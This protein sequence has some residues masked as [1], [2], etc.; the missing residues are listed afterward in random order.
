M[1]I[2]DRDKDIKR[3]YDKLELGAEVHRLDFLLINMLGLQTKIP[4]NSTAN[5]IMGE[6]ITLLQGKRNLMVE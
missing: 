1:C 6:A 4:E 2:R 3:F 5:K